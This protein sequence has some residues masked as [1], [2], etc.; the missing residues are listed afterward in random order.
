MDVAIDKAMSI[1]N[2]KTRLC[3][4]SAHFNLKYTF[5]RKEGKRKN[6]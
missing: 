6:K 2:G 4:G 3:F 1:D 5:C